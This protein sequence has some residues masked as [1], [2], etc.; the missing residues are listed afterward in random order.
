[1]LAIIVAKLSDKQ[2]KFQEQVDTA[3]TAMKNIN[4]DK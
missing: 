3:N 4:L 1:M 2:Q